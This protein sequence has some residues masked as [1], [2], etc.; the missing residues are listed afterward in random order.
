MATLTYLLVLERKW[1]QMMEQQMQRDR[2]ELVY[3]KAEGEYQST[4]Y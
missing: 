3:V 1:R 4:R 2:L